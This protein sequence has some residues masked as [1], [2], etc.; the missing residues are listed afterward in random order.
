M[1]YIVQELKN[2]Y[3]LDWQNLVSS[4]E[5]GRLRAIFRQAN[6][7]TEELIEQYKIDFAKS[8]QRQRLRGGLGADC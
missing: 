3:G 8:N 7:E 4:G 6:E 2:H 1:D 5:L